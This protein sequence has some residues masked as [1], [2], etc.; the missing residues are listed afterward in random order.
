MHVRILLHLLLHMYLMYAPSNSQ[1]GLY[2]GYTSILQQH[3]RGLER[4]KS[5]PVPVPVPDLGQPALPGILA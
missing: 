2:P 5:F 3:A 1:V 4:V